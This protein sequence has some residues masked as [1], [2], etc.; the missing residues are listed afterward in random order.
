MN[1]TPLTPNY[2]IKHPKKNLESDDYLRGTKYRTLFGGGRP[3]LI[4]TR[5]YQLK[6]AGLPAVFS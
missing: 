6:T 5:P 4:R 3:L 1:F 2:E